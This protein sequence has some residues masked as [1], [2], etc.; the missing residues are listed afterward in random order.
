M[1]TIEAPKVSKP[2]WSGGAY[3]IAFVY[4]NK[5]NFIIKGF[6]GDVDELLRK[7]KSRGYQY[8]VNLT[9]WHNKTHRRIWKCS[10]RGV[11]ING[12]TLNPKSNSILS[13][14]Y[15]FKISKYN[16]SGKK[17]AEYKLKRMP[18]RYIKE[19]FE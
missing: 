15:H 2:C 7:Y 10:I 8:F 6:Y 16:Q 17:A 13:F 11:Y 5:G 3:T 4:S 9:L 12:P 1:K 18:S 14:P 19:I